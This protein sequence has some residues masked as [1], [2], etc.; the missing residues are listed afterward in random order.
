MGAP[1]QT[2]A[3]LLDAK[4]WA[5]D[6]VDD[7]KLLIPRGSELTAGDLPLEDEIDEL[8]ETLDVIYKRVNA[9]DT[10]LEL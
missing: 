8:R 3:N 10:R 7:L 2:R 4:K 5:E 1:E 6:L 9:C